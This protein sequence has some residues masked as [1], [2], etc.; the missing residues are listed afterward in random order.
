MQPWL[1]L[2]QWRPVATFA[3]GAFLLLQVAC[4]LRPSGAINLCGQV[5][6]PGSRNTAAPGAAVL[7]LGVRCGTKAGHPQSYVIGAPDCGLALPLLTFA[8]SRLCAWTGSVL[9]LRQSL[10]V[11][12]D[13]TAEIFSAL[14]GPR[15]DSAAE[16]LSS[17][18]AARLPRWQITALT[19]PGGDC[20]GSDV[21]R[22]GH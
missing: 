18:F 3:F 19:L 5:L 1:L 16:W 20:S 13:T 8:L 9:R 10:R 22:R 4:C 6:L 14:L 21:P 17:D 7:H 2:G 12:L 11:Y 15:A